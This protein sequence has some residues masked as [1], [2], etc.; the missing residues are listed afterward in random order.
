MRGGGRAHLT[1]CDEAF[2]SELAECLEES[3]P[4]LPSLPLDR[5]E[6]CGHEVAEDHGR[7]LWRPINDCTCSYCVE[8]P[9]E[10]AEPVERPGIRL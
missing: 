1:T 4:R 10:D 9:V 7:P 8:R 5:E 6:R 2:P 3:V